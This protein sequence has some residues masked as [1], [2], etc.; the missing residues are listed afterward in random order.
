MDPEF[1]A[2][3]LIRTGRFGHRHTEEKPCDGGRDGRDVATSS[4][5]PGP[6]RSWKRQESSYLEPREGSQPCPDLD[7]KP[8]ASEL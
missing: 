7:L 5:T 2:S 4:E 6:P 3:V 1:N 8:L